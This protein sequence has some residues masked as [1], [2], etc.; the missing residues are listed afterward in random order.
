MNMWKE[1][2][3]LSAMLLLGGC[4]ASLTGTDL[5]R[6]RAAREYD[7]PR[8]HVRVK[9]LSAGPKGYQI[10]KVAACGTIAT[11]ACNTRAESCMKESDDQR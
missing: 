5:A 11:Y 10:Y 6:A 7:C 4:E 3:A 2:G 9:W 8:E 1:L